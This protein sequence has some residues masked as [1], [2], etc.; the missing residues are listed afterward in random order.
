[1]YKFGTLR[2]Y[3]PLVEEAERARARHAKEIEAGAGPKLA[4]AVL[5]DGTVSTASA[6]SSEVH[7]PQLPTLK[8]ASPSTGSLLTTTQV[9][10]VT[11]RP[12]V[13]TPATRAAQI[14]AVPTST[15]QHGAVTATTATPTP[16]ASVP[17]SVRQ[18]QAHGTAEAMDV[19]VEGTG[20]G[21]EQ[22]DVG[23]DVEIE[24]GAEGGGSS[25]HPGTAAAVIGGGRALGSTS[26]AGGV[27]SGTQMEMD[28]RSVARGG[29]GAVGTGPSGGVSVPGAATVASRAASLVAPVGAGGGRN[30][31]HG[32]AEVA[33]SAA[34]TLKIAREPPAPRED[35]APRKFALGGPPEVGDSIQEVKVSVC[36]L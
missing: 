28:A 11:A 30:P 26:A 3:M 19:D 34:A 24:V 4:K 12:A 10:A 22:V 29:A 23:D 5:Q 35:G 27:V 8:N 18:Q 1:M 7:S 32:G 15:T 20:A 33:N 25:N 14:A 17:L 9:A 31:V 36:G 6:I 16:V 13:D 2:H 21:E